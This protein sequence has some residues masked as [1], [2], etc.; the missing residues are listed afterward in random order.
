MLFRSGMNKLVFLLVGIFLISSV[1][2][3]GI[4]PARTTINFE[5]GLVKTVNFNII[6]SGGK[7]LKVIFS[8][9]GDLAK[10]ISISSEDGEI[11]A[12][13]K[14]KTFSYT[15]RL[16]KYLKPGLHKGGIFVMQL[17]S[18]NVSGN[19]Q[20][21]ATL[22]V[23]TQVYL[24]VSYPGK[25]ATAQM[26]VY[27]ANQG[28]NVKFVIP[29]VNAGKFDLTSVYANIDVYNNMGRKIT[30][31]NTKTV[32]IK[33]GARKELVYN[34]KANVPIGEYQ[35]K[36]TL[37]YDDGTLN[38]EKTFS[39]GN[40]NLVLQS[41]KV[42]DFSLGQIAKLQMLVENKWSEP[43]KDAYIETNIKDS[44]GD[45]ISSFKS[46]SYNIAALSKQNFVSY[47][48]TA[49][50]LK[51]TYDAEISINYANKTSGKHLQFKVEQ[52]KLTVIGLGY[53]VSTGGDGS[54]STTT[55]LI[56]IIVLLV[57]INL[58]WF[59]I[60]RKRLKK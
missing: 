35:A 21:Q 54:N 49:G 28:E 31:F 55:I 14:S 15:L 47:W 30:S 51:G 41:I 44:S 4:S 13:E 2:A 5:P 23:V 32:E 50:V 57:L 25:Y 27:N 12:S 33:T 9:Q 60:L 1:Y 8:A 26:Y 3:L 48:D 38:I 19:S 37:V 46:A 24:Y 20:I 52:N 17:P 34:W 29:V 39:I 22:A 11:P 59:F 6:N 53:V 7:D 56:T 42:N 10:Y 40:K 58:L 16:P 45:L 43:I 36:A 18:G